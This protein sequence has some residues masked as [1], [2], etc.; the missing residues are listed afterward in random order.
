MNETEKQI[1]QKIHINL[2]NVARD[3]VP[4]EDDIY[5]LAE[6]FKVFGDSTRMRILC[7][8]S[9]SDAPVCA[10]A[11][12]LGMTPS[13]ISHQL[14]ILKDN[15]LVKCRRDGQSQ[16]YFLADAHVRSIISAGLDHIK[17]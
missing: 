2:R 17:E 7:V 11:D 10:L 15:K 3:R 12:V 13:A 9:E 1:H 14:R 6:L 5:D 4:P 16:I 8:L